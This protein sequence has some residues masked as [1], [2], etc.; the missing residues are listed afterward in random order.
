M[1]TC[2]HCD[3]KLDDDATECKHCGRDLIPAST[4]AAG[5]G[6]AAF[7]SLVIPG[8]GQIYVQG[9]GI[10]ILWLVVTI[11]CYVFFVPLGM[12]AHILSVLLAATVGGER[13]PARGATRESAPPADGVEPLGAAH[14]VKPLIVT[15]F[16]ME[17][18]FVLAWLSGY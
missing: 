16:S 7:L 3:G 13:P 14:T 9:V 17:L 6:I 10:G 4:R 5:A 11:A 15:V 8:A 12:L 2:P 18:M 1:T